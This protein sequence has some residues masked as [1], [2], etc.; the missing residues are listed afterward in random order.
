M[1]KGLKVDYLAEKNSKSFD[2][3]ISNYELLE[4][5]AQQKDL[6]SIIMPCFNSEQYLP[7]TIESVIAQTYKNWELLIVDDGSKDGSVEIIEQYQKKCDQ[8][9]LLSKN[10]Y[11]SADCR[12]LA[13]KLASGRYFAFLDSDDIWH[14]DYLQTMVNNIYTCKVSNAAIYYAGYRRMDANCLFPVL[15]DY[16]CSGVKYR[17]DLLRHCPIFPSAC[18]IDSGKMVTPTFFR[19]DLKSLRDDYVFW[20]DILKQNLVAVGFED[21]IVDYRMRE[22]SMTASKMKMIKPQWGVYR[23][24]LR[25]NW[26]MSFYYLTCWGLNGLR[27][28]RKFVFWK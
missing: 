2:P 23:K 21:I 27:K 16:S 8:V 3:A 19:T 22:N 10:N 4:L 15:G 1:E 9:H 28:Y 7:Q 20:L 13:M 12:N 26:F 6:I 11:G 17:K 25:M 18:I 5:A 24:V 14:A